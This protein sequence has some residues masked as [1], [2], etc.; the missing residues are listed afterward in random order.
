MCEFKE[1]APW[2]A[3]AVVV[4]FTITW[5]TAAIGIEAHAAHKQM[6]M[7]ATLGCV[8]TSHFASVVIV[9]ID[10]R[11]AHKL[12]K[13]LS[14]THTR[15][16]V[17]NGTPADKTGCPI[18]SGKAGCYHSHLRALEA[19]SATTGWHLILEDD[20]I[21]GRHV[22]TSPTWFSDIVRRLGSHVDPS[23]VVVNLGP[24]DIRPSAHLFLHHFIQHGTD[25][26]T[27]LV[28]GKTPILGGFG[29]L[30]HAYAVTHTGAQTIVDALAMAGC[31]GAGIDTDLRDMR[32]SHP[33]TFWRV[34]DTDN[35]GHRAWGLFSQSVHVSGT[36][37]L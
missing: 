15:P 18:P 36:S 14:C 7:A 29:T 2:V 20:A 5:L 8:D 23:A 4:L 27:Y 34:F 22:L 6:R 25:M 32:Q 33:K 26:L 35:R 17:L 30:T 11:R 28:A 9:S 16:V 13:S 31:R 3:T 12:V 21:P 24:N 37:G 10:T 1:A 19:A